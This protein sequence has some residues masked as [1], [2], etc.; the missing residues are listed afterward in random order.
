[1]HEDMK[2]GGGNEYYAHHIR[3]RMLER[4]GSPPL[5][6]KCELQLVQD[7]MLLLSG[8]GGEEEGEGQGDIMA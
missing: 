3:K 1:M 5:Q 8:T 2:L 7:A 6:L 4:Q